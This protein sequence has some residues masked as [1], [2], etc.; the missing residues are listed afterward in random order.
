MIKKIRLT[1]KTGFSDVFSADQLFGQFIWAISDLHGE[2]VASDLLAK[3]IEKPGLLFSACMPEGFFPFANYLNGFADG[4][5][6][7]GKHNK[8]CKWIRIEDFSVFQKEPFKFGTTLL[9]LVGNQVII[10]SSEAHVSIDRNT[11]SSKEKGLYNKQYLYSDLPLC[12][13]LSIDDDQIGFWSSYIMDVCDYWSH[14]GLGGDKNTGHGQFEVELLD[15]NAIENEVFLFDKGDAFISLS[16]C[17]GLDLNPVNY[18][19]DVYSGIMGRGKTGSTRYRKM[20]I[21]R[22][23]EGSLFLSGVGEIKQGTGCSNDICSYGYAFPVRVVF[24]GGLS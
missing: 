4:G 19:V 20:P 23:L 16:C 13:Y 17:F 24:D 22:F 9:D 8:K 5:S 3:L 7:L 1:P 6:E 10:S 15:P 14:V 12:F 11:L 21:V 2:Q 18:L